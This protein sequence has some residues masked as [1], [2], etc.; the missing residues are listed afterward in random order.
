MLQVH[1]ED[2]LT[3][4]KDLFS[5]IFFFWKLDCLTSVFHTSFLAAIFIHSTAEEIP[6]HRSK[7]RI[8]PS[9]LYYRKISAQATNCPLVLISG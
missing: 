2:F 9:A 4:Q 8:L 1:Q 3:L 7:Q 5:T 6:A